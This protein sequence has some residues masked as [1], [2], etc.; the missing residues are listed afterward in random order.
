PMACLPHLFTAHKAPQT[1]FL[2]C[3]CGIVWHRRVHTVNDSLEVLRRLDYQVTEKRD[4][5][6]GY[7]LQISGSNML[8][9][10]LM[11]EGIPLYLSLC[12]IGS[13]FLARI[14]LYC[15]P[16]HSLNRRGN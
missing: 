16:F 3:L 1:S 12:V 13:R 8:M 5:Q 4:L 15:R 10:W 14:I 7:R 9:P 11:Y 2:S 6:L